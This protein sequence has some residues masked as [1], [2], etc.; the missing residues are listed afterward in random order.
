MYIRGASI[1]DLYAAL[2]EVNKRYAGNIDFKRLEQ[3]GRRILFTLRARDCRGKGGRLNSTL[4]RHVGAAACWHAHGHLFA[5]LFRLQPAAS[6]NSADKV[7]TGPGADAGNWQ[8]WNIG[9]RAA[10]V[11]F[12]QACYCE[13]A[14][15]RYFG[16]YSNVTPRTAAENSAL[17]GRGDV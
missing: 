13:D 17:E 2:A 6:I 10:P 15:G 8:D 14:D 5:E 11:Y 9:S 12:S 16:D 1:A 4:T 3:K 7:I